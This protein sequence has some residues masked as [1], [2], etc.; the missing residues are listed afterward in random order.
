MLQ[1]DP[2]VLCSG[3]NTITIPTEKLAKWSLVLIWHSEK[4]SKRWMTMET[5]SF[6]AVNSKWVYSFCRV[7]LCLLSA[8]LLAERTS[9]MCAKV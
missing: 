8:H 6:H 4:N 2:S 3:E 1:A 7:C 9:F 5:E